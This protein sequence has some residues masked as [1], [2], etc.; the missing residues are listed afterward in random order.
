MPRHGAQSVELRLERTSPKLPAA[1]CLPAR[2]IPRSDLSERPA[3]ASEGRF[4]GGAPAPPSVRR[5]RRG[6][7]APIANPLAGSNLHGLRCFAGGQNSTALADEACFG[8][9]I[10]P[11]QWVSDVSPA[12]PQTSKRGSGRDRRAD[13]GLCGTRCPPH[14]SSP[15][16]EETQGPASRRCRRVLLDLRVSGPATCC[17]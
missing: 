11:K 1:H 9:A 3:C 17:S 2:K 10:S 8:G 5:S 15:G 13:E 4:R 14:F 16:F 7:P 6:R 12:Q